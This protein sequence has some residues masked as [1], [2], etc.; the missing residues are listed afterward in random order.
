MSE[1]NFMVKNCASL[2]MEALLN[3]ASYMN[4]NEGWQRL[5]QCKHSTEAQNTC[6]VPV[7]K[8]LL[9]YFLPATAVTVD[10]VI[11]GYLLVPWSGRSV[12]SA[13][14]RILALGPIPWQR[15]RPDGAEPQAA[16]D[17]VRQLGDHGAVHGR[18]GAVVGQLQV[19]A[20]QHIEGRLVGETRFLGSMLAI[21]LPFLAKVSFQILLTRP[22]ANDED[23]DRVELTLYFLRLAPWIVRPAPP[24]ARAGTMMAAIRTKFEVA[25]ERSRFPE[26]DW[27]VVGITVAYLLT[28]PSQQLADMPA[29]PKNGR[30][31]DPEGKPVEGCLLWFLCSS[32]ICVPPY[33]FLK[34]CF[35]GACLSFSLR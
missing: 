23:E 34:G 26:S 18:R 9:M 29:P 32:Q 15:R 14:A 7:G 27:T 24:S 3:I 10:V 19:H 30:K 5:K 33:S 21:R 1:N 12:V 13:P 8:C 28:A 17:A 22:A 25:L 16:P 2:P 11:G 4:G 6:L 35:R 20:L 31:G